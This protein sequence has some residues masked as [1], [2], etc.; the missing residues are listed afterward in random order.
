MGEVQTAFKSSTS[1]LTQTFI[2]N[3]A[4]PAQ[5]SQAFLPMIEKSNKKT[6]V[7]ISSGL[8]SFGR[9]FGPINANYSVTKAALNMLVRPILIYPPALP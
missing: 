8:G 3:V 4:G 1:D 5:V 7:N 2:A 6:I 9:G